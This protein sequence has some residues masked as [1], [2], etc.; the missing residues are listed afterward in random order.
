MGAHPVGVGLDEG[1]ALAGAGG[2]ERGLGHGVHGEHVVAVDPDAGEA[3]AAGAVPE[4]G[5]GLLL[6]GLGDG[7]LVVLAEEHDRAV[8]DAGE[9]ER[10]GDVALAGGAVAEVGDDGGVAVVV[11][12]ADAAV[13]LHAHGVAGGVQGLRADDD[14][15]EVEVLLVGVPAAVV[16]PAEHA[17][18][19]DRVDP[20][21]PGDA[22]LAVGGEGVVLGAQ[23]PAGADLR[24]LLA[25]EAGPQAQLALALERGGLGVEAADE[26]QVAVEPAQL[27]VGQRVDDGV[28]LGVRDALTLGVEQLDHLRAAVLDGALGGLGAGDVVVHAERR[29]ERGDLV[30]AHRAL[31]LRAP[32]VTVAAS[33]SDARWGVARPARPTGSS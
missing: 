10:L 32:V 21:A 15:V 19:V 5:A 1:R 17:E 18:Q 31:L 22:V 33:V 9:D 6:V 13:A 27:L 4:R 23:R 20:A 2:V 16:D 11:A 12:G 3:E 28:V 29:L 8:V 30:V 24:G 14:R 25:E 26:D 7:P